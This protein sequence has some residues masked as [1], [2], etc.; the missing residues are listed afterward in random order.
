MAQTRKQEEEV[1][2]AMQQEPPTH[3]HPE[4]YLFSLKGCPG[5][6]GYIPKNLE[7]EVCKYCGQ[8]NYYH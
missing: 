8:I 4:R 1:N 2:E 5:Y 6:E 7:H 3:W